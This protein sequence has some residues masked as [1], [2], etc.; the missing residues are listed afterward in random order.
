MNERDDGR[1]DEAEDGAAAATHGRR[2]LR[3]RRG[4]LAARANGG[5]GRREAGEGRDEA[6]PARLIGRASRELDEAERDVPFAGVVDTD[7]GA[8]VA[9]EGEDGSAGV[10]RGE[11]GA[12]LIIVD[13][14]INVDRVVEGRIAG[15]NLAVDAALL[16]FVIPG[17]LLAEHEVH[18]P[19][20]EERPLPAATPIPSLDVPRRGPLLRYAGLDVKRVGRAR[21]KWT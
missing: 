6:R 20:D 16:G 15:L 17:G 18:G 5:Q 3:V 9:E 21:L 7:L 11:D 1:H 2:G 14:R 4:R 8:I 10:R 19:R 13:Q 12:D